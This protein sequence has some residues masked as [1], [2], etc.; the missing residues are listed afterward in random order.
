MGETTPEMCG[1]QRQGRERWSHRHVWAWE[2]IL[3]ELKY[4]WK[5]VWRRDNNPFTFLEPLHIY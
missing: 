5:L 3:S 1:E 2:K 4:S